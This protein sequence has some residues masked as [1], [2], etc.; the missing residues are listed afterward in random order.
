MGIKVLKIVIW[1]GILH[2]LWSQIVF[3]NDTDVSLLDEIS[4]HKTDS[5]SPQSDKYGRVPQK[6]S[7]PSSCDSGALTFHIDMHLRK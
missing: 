1:G 6:C 3:H 4:H 5:L 7:H 2:V